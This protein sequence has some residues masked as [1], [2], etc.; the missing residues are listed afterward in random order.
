MSHEYRYV[1]SRV[2]V[3]IL[4]VRCAM[5]RGLV[6]LH[7]CYESGKRKII[8]PFEL[9]WDL[10]NKQCEAGIDRNVSRVPVRVFKSTRHIMRTL[11]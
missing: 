4:C 3:G 11:R 2:L 9:C 5:I 8:R 10:P 7:L 6:L 1:Y